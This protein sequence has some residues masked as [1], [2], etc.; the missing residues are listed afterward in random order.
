MPLHAHKLLH[1][2]TAAISAH[3]NRFATHASNRVS[4]PARALRTHHDAV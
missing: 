4:N 2:P 3:H 1:K